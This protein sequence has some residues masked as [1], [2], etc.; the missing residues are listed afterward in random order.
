MYATMQKCKELDDFMIP[1]MR[2]VVC[3]DGE[4]L[5]VLVGGDGIPLFY[6]T[7]YVTAELRGNGLAV[8]TNVNALTAIKSLYAWQEYFGIDLEVR[9]K[10]NQLLEAHEIHALRDF[11]QKPLRNGSSKKVVSIKRPKA[12]ESEV[13]YARMSV[14]ASY[15]EFLAGKLQRATDRSA[16]AT[17]TMVSQIK[18][19]RPQKAGRSDADRED[20]HLDDEMLDSLQAILRPGSESNPVASYAVQVRNALLFTITRITGFRRGELL[21]LKIDD[22]DFSSNVISVVRR[23]DS[24]GDVRVNQPTA[25]TY[26]RP[27]PVQPDL[28]RRIYEYVTQFR[29][30]VPGANR[31]G[32][33]FVV[34]KEG[35]HLGRP[36]SNSAFG[37]VFEQ[38]KE[39]AAGYAGVHAHSLRHHWNYTFSQY[40]DSHGISAAEEERTRSFLMGWKATS[41]TAATYNRRHTKERAA[42]ATLGIQEKHLMNMHKENKE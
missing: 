15:L 7:L 39:A 5:V 22:I 32:Y 3:S 20:K 31:H 35:P 6:P 38:V 30:K 11:L 37:K 28:I 1:Q 27:Y 40:A 21:N 34:H 41:G 16:D 4:R 25:K 42:K 29:N 17:A 23:P 8:N 33:L 14:I 24:P 2:R 36:L 12:V 10:N 13:Q 19:N 18:A 26:G 9:F